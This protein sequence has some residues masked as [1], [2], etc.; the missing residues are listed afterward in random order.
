ME[1][2]SWMFSF[3]PMSFWHWLVDMMLLAGIVGIVA[4]LFISFIPFVNKWRY[5]IK[6]VSLV[7]LIIGAYFKG[8]FVVE[9]RWQARV[10]SLKAKVAV[11]EEKSKTANAEIQTKIV[12]RT[13][14]VHDTKIIT[15]EVLK[16]KIVA[17]DTQCSVSDVVTVLNKAATRPVLKLELPKE[18]AK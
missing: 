10:E 8:G 14:L 13:K 11:A 15:K 1:Q 7:L 9:D 12:T 18:E 5:V 3:I 16:E 4:G 6:P 2:I 17:I